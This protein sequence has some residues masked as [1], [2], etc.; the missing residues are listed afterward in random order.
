MD[1]FTYTIAKEDWC[2]GKYDKLNYDMLKEIWGFTAFVFL[3]MI[4]DMLYW[5]TDKVLI[6]ALI[7][8]VAVAVYNIGGVL[9]QW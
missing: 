8:S 7:G 2:K 3:G 6:G 4:V 9:L 1:M 5:A